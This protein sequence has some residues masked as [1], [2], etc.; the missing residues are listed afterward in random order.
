VYWTVAQ[1]ESQREHVARQ[2]LM[3][4][5]FV[6][7]CPRIKRKGSIVPLFPAYVF[8]QI[9]SAWYQARWTVGITRILMDGERPAKLADDI[10]TA[11]QG[12][13]VGGLVVLP[14]APR[15]KPGQAVRVVRGSFQNRVG[16]YEGMI[17]RDREKILLDLL[18]QKVAVVLP[19]RDVAAIP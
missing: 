17:G 18:G 16:I 19:G 14:R 6:T 12:R 9:E 15:M 7:Y 10:I 2:F 3:R 5:G 11:I 4:A 8:I 13:E 1:T